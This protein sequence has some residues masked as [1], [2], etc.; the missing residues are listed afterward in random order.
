MQ[1]KGQW[2]SLSSFLTY[3]T[4]LQ[5]SVPSLELELT[6]KAAFKHQEFNTVLV[7]GGG[8]WEGRV[9]VSGHRKGAAVHGPGFVEL[10]NFTPYQDT[11]GAMNVSRN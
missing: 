6:V 8:F 10:K 3:P 11:K 5:I 7:T 1:S 4:E 2:T 9:E